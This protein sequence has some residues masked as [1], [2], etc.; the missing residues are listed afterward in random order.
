MLPMLMLTLC[1]ALC[2]WSVVCQTG[3]LLSGLLPQLLSGAA[4][5]ELHSAAEAAMLRWS[6]AQPLPDGS[7]D[8]SHVESQVMQLLSVLAQSLFRQQPAALA[9][10]GA[11]FWQPFVGAYEAAFLQQI[12]GSDANT[13]SARQQAAANMEQQA[14]SMGLAEPGGWME[15][16]V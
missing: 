12:K 8:T 9:A 16:D 14:V 3:V 10:F 4:Y 2:C 5:L 15:W 13:I 6:P 1:C 11:A 7:Y